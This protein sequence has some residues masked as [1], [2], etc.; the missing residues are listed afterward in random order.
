M[1]TL[2][3]LRL[4]LAAVFAFALIPVGGPALAQAEGQ[5]YLKERHGDWEVRCIAAQGS[6]E[7]QLYQLL[8]DQDG[9]PV[10]VIKIF[11]LPPG[12]E[13]RT[14]GTIIAPLETLLTERLRWQVNGGRALTYPFSFCMAE[15]CFVQI[16][17]R[18]EEIN[19][20]RA[21]TTATV[22]ISH[23][24]IP[25]RPVVLTVSLAGFTKGFAALR[26][27]STNTAE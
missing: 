27:I 15:G 25:D 20:M 21:G 7:C 11:Q 22:T 6:E 17:F 10:V 12:R 9:N 26:Q 8:R 16:G 24:A 1:P 19:Q 14:G 23:V 3:P 18:D 2:R 4:V 13:V 5:V